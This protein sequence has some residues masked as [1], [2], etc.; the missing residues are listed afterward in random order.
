MNVFFSLTLA[1]ILTF[2]G[3]Q[4]FQKSGYPACEMLLSDYVVIGQSLML[5]VSLELPMGLRVDSLK[6]SKS[7]KAFKRQ[8]FQR[9]TRDAASMKNGTM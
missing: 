5:L 9:L 6:I 4:K 2:P 8:F 1:E 3:F 7:S